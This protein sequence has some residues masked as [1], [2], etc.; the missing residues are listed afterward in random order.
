MTVKIRQMRQDD[1][2]LISDGLTGQNQD[3]VIFRR[4]GYH[5]MYM[6]I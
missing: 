3:M 5:P 6:S 2:E 4:M 1:I